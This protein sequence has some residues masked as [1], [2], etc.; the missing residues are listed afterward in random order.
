MTGT[1]GTIVRRTAAAYPL[2]TTGLDGVATWKYD[3]GFGG[4]DVGLGD[5]VILSDPLDSL[6]DVVVAVDALSE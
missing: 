3:D 1:D 4:G 6:D 5:D 2:N